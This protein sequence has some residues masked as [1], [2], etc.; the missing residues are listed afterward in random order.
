MR[1]KR[2]TNHGSIFPVVCGVATRN[3]GTNRLLEAIVE[4]LPSPVEHGAFETDEVTLEPDESGALRLRVQDA[5]RPL[6]RADQPAARLSRASAP[7]HATAQHAHPPKERIGQLIV[8]AGKGTTAVEELGPATSAPS[9]SSRRL[10][11]ATGWRRAM[12]RSDARRRSPAPV[13]AFAIEPKTRATR[14]RSSPR[15]AACRRRTRRSTCTATPDRRADRR[16]PVADPRRGDRRSPALALR[17]RGHAEAAARALPGDDP[18]LGAKAH[19]RHK[20]QSGGRGQF[21]DCHIE[22]EPLEPGAGFEFVDRSRAA[23]FRARSS[24][25]SRRACA[26]RWTTACSPAIPSRT[27]A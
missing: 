25:R 20:K 17:R 21:G 22:I 15:C 9:R 5:R 23:R 14:T 8:F 4:D 16:R 7:R 2:G 12:S 13:M 27:C 24:R 1:C 26:R 11:P 10:A 18:R 19:G 6:R 3:L